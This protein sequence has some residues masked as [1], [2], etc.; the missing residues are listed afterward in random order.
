MTKKKLAFILVATRR[1]NFFIDQFYYTCEKFFFPEAEKHYFIVSDSKRLIISEKFDN[2]TLVDYYEIVGP[3]DNCFDRWFHIL[4]TVFDDYDI[5]NKFDAVANGNINFR[6]ID[7]FNIIIKH[8]Y[9]QGKLMFV[10]HSLTDSIIGNNKNEDLCHDEYSAA[11]LPVEKY[12]VKWCYGGWFLG[13]VNLAYRYI[14]E[15]HEYEKHDN[16]IGYRPRW[17]D[18]NYTNKWINLN[19]DSCEFYDT[20]LINFNLYA[21]EEVK[22]NHRGDKIFNLWKSFYFNDVRDETEDISSD[23]KFY[24]NNVSESFDVIR[25]DGAHD[26]LKID[27]N[28]NCFLSISLR[29]GNIID[30]DENS[31]SIILDGSEQLNLILVGPE[32]LVEIK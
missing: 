26:I 14:S 18:E 24:D 30:R 27:V 3:K 5:K 2:V 22:A 15:C 4:K 7:R 12:V 21:T 11:Y 13:N 1:Y 29:C 25:K 9:E 28:G 20:S 32:K 17:N 6:F 10:Y 19:L 8:F 23:Y 16:L 31:L